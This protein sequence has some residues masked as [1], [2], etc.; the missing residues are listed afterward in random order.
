[1]ISYQGVE[2]EPGLVEKIKKWP[3]PQSPVEIQSF[4]GATNYYRR[5]LGPGYS[6]IVA[7]VQECVTKVPF[8][9][10]IEGYAAFEQVLDLMS[11][12]DMLQPHP[13]FSRPFI[14][15]TDASNFGIGAAL[16]QEDDEGRLRTINVCSR[17]LGPSERRYS[18]ISREALAIRYAFEKFDPIVYGYQVRV[19]TDQKPLTKWGQLRVFPNDQMQR[20]WLAYLQ[21]YDMEI[22]YRPGDENGL[23]DGLSRINAKATEN[24]R[25]DVQ[26]DVLEHLD[27]LAEQSG[28]VEKYRQG[29]TPDALFDRAVLQEEQRA[30]VRRQKLLA[31]LKSKRKV[32]FKTPAQK[33]KGEGADAGTPGEPN[34][35]PAIVAAMGTVLRSFGQD[36]GEKQ[37]KK[38][39]SSPGNSSLKGAKKRN[40]AIRSVLKRVHFDPELPST[41]ADTDPDHWEVE[42]YDGESPGEEEPREEQG[43]DE[44]GVFVCPIPSLTSERRSFTVNR[45]EY[46]GEGWKYETPTVVRIPTQ[47]DRR[48]KRPL[49]DPRRWDPENR[50]HISPRVEWKE[51]FRN[52]GR[53]FRMLASPAAEE[54]FPRRVRRDGESVEEYADDLREVA[55][56]AFP[57]YSDN[58]LHRRLCRAFV[59]GLDNP[60]RERMIQKWD[61]WDFPM[62]VAYTS[63]IERVLQPLKWTFTHLRWEP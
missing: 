14:I 20:W 1:M 56:R 25:L 40:V 36:K 19:F 13:D 24:S 15:S 11:S 8:R 30:L 7:P 32:K 62:L 51:Y 21:Q 27:Q 49:G 58:A 33:S 43:G 3:C 22:F 46:G 52:P 63:A 60:L 54:L 34:T 10:T 16:E 31:E 18:T 55:V 2:P 61:D 17:T 59:R 9:L 42:S 50:E 41:S 23:A 39:L 47:Q 6:T 26:T 44:M 5:F 28:H 38:K 48:V 35:E 12:G 53:R 57:R 4:L 29:A 45:I 37:K